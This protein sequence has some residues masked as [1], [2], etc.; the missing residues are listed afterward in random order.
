MGGAG[1]LQLPWMQMP[2]TAGSGCAR[3]GCTRVCVRYLC[4]CAHTRPGVNMEG[5][6]APTAKS[7]TLPNAST[8]ALSP[9]DSRD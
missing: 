8:P 1:G 5:G 4:V 9:T 3:E 6:A 2:R 7:P